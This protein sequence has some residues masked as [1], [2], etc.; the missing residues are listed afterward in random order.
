MKYNAAMPQV[1]K[2]EIWSVSQL[3]RQVKSL[4]EAEISRVWVQ[5][6]ISN[7][8][9]A[10]SGHAYFTLK[11]KQS[12]VDAVMF[13]GRLSKVKFEPDAGLEV[14]VYGLVTVYERRGNYQIVC[15]EMQP[16]GVGALQLALEKLKQ[17][18]TPNTRSPCRSCR[19]RSAW[20]PRLRA[21]PFAIFSM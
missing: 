5:G 1:E 11:D 17:K 7:W 3:T 6:E 4:L 12:Q 19:G 10:A 20:S 9:L 14:I 21:R 16:K 15:E 2:P 13:K 18:L 8:R